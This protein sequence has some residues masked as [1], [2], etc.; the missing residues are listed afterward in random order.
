MFYAFCLILRLLWT[1]PLYGY[2]YT[3][4]KTGVQQ[5]AAMARVLVWRGC[6]R[7]TKAGVVGWYYLPTAKARFTLIRVNRSPAFD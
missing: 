7:K 1:A 4:T 3:P 2:H 6:Q 5:L